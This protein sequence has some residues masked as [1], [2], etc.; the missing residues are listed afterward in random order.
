M[1]KEDEQTSLPKRL[2]LK[3]LQKKTSESEGKRKTQTGKIRRKTDS[4]TTKRNDSQKRGKEECPTQNGIIKR[5][6]VIDHFRRDGA[7]AQT[8]RRRKDASTTSAT[9]ITNRGN[10]EV[11]AKTAINVG[12]GARKSSPDHQYQ[13]ETVQHKVARGNK[14]KNRINPAA[15]LVL[16]M[17]WVLKKYIQNFCL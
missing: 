1:F 7:L 14:P 6:L 13:T 16:S 12:Q 17:K 11:N 8:D 15:Y 5:G 4:Q 10:E 3:Q 9:N 2:S